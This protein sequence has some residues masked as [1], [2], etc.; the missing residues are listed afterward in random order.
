MENAIVNAY[1]IHTN[2]GYKSIELYNA[3]ICDF[4]K[5]LDC[6]VFSAFQSSY[7]PIPNTLIEA[8]ENTFNIICSDLA[9]KPAIDLRRE[10]DVWV[11]S[12]IS[13][14]VKRLACVELNRLNDVIPDYPVIINNLFT[15]F[16]VMDQLGMKVES[17]ALPVIGTGNQKIK[18]ELIIPSVIEG[19]I[20]GLEKIEQ[21]KK[22]YIVELSTEKIIY[23][24]KVMNDYLKRS[25]EDIHDIFGTE[26]YHAILSE[27]K[28]NVKGLCIIK[29]TDSLMEFVKK[30][31]T[32]NIRTFE[33]GILSR[34]ICEEMVDDLGN[35]QQKAKN[36]SLSEKISNLYRKNVAS[37]IISYFHTIRIFG[38]YYAHNNLSVSV[39]PDKHSQQDILLLISSL[40]RIIL[41]YKNDYLKVE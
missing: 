11:S 12:D 13:S 15:L 40:N 33:L 21:L 1:E 35:Y 22:V 36:Y 38:N 25:E 30:L 24:D 37:W 27:L 2:W 17:I 31:Q 4:P 39:Y 18:P 8:I 16:T 10:F 26:Y 41:F 29:Q 23:F 34:R 19:S 7:L 5:D 20:R 9:K 14:K 28:E 32:G 6:L 3:D